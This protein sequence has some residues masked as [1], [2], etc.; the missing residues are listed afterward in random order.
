MVGSTSWNNLGVLFHEYPSAA[1]TW[2]GSEALELKRT[3]RKICVA[4]AVD[5]VWDSKKC[6]RSCCVCA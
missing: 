5:L 6:L 1:G 4:I 2:G 3:S